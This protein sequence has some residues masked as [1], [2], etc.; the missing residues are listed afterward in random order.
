MSK[1]IKKLQNITEAN[2]RLEHRLLNEQ[3]QSTYPECVSKMGKETTGNGLKFIRGTGKWTG[4]SFFSNGRVALQGRKDVYDYECSGN[5]IL[6]GNMKMI[7]DHSGWED[8]VEYYKNNSDSNWKFQT[9]DTHYVENGD[10]IYKSIAS[11]STDGSDKTLRVYSDGEVY[12]FKS[13]SEDVLD[14]G[15]WSMSGGKP[16]F[17]LESDKSSSET[18]TDT[19]TP[20]EIT[21]RASGYVNDSD[22]DMKEAIVDK[23]KIMTRGSKG[24]LVQEVQHKLLNIEGYDQKFK[25]T[26]D[27]EGCK[28][29]VSRCDGIYGSITKQAVRQY[30]KD[31]GL[32]K[33]GVVGK[34]TAKSMGLI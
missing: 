2:I 25:L 26:K 6:I 7:D 33:D 11:I 22:T 1:Y 16:V 15:T 3:Q 27:V 34:Q 13:G 8:I 32:S 29:E 18:T 24:M 21:T 9:V 31:K 14:K 28:S 4:S 5:E 30:Q 20:G 19:E 12:I 17:K 23:N 10:Y